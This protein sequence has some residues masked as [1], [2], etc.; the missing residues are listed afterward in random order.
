MKSKAGKVSLLGER[1]KFKITSPVVLALQTSIYIYHR[2]IY[3]L[4]GEYYDTLI[5]KGK[6]L[7]YGHYILVYNN[8][9]SNV[10]MERTI[11]S[12]E[13]FNIELRHYKT[14][15][16][17]NTN[18]PADI[19]YILQLDNK[20][21]TE[22]DKILF[23]V[24]D[25][26]NHIN[27]YEIYQDISDTEKV[28]T[29]VEYQESYT[30]LVQL[31]KVYRLHSLLGDSGCNEIYGF[32]LKTTV[33]GTNKDNRNILFSKGTLLKTQYKKVYE[34]DSIDYIVSSIKDTIKIKQDILC[35]AIDNNKTYITTQTGIMIYKLRY[36]LYAP[37]K[38]HID[39][40]GNRIQLFNKHGKIIEI[41]K[42]LNIKD[43]IEYTLKGE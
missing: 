35:R 15:S 38:I 22:T 18:L 3:K 28:I 31:N 27:Y 17:Q 20:E 24:S 4:N 9:L 1:V 40:T 26:N 29:K 30:Y 37:I 42:I 43:F 23:K 16:R 14:I 5:N 7:Q 6:I 41:G 12:I 2:D 8:K 13:D 19:D 32:G 36:S 21:T 25:N 10:Y 33:I 11:N 39:I 34:A